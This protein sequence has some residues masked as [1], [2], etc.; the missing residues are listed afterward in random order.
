MRTYFH[1]HNTAASKCLLTKIKKKAWQTKGWTI[2]FWVGNV[3]SEYYIGCGG[4]YKTI[5]SY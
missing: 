5:Q 3:R 1:N 2:A 4:K